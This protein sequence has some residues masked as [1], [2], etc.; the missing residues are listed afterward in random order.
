MQFG[1][2]K[3][4]TSEEQEKRE[5]WNNVRVRFID[6]YELSAHQDTFATAWDAARKLDAERIKELEAELNECKYIISNGE[7]H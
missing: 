3:M 7:Y 1:K 4:K 6:I 5:L 2:H